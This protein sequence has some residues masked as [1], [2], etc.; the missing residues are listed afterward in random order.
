MFSFKVTCKLISHLI[1]GLTRWKFYKLF[2]FYFK[3]RSMIKAQKMQEKYSNLHELFDKF[4]SRL[5]A[6]EF[7]GESTPD[8][9]D[10]KVS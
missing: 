3:E 1:D 8:A 4:S 6:N 7:H 10:F 9:A 2:Y 5:N